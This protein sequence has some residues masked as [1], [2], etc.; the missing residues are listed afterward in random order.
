MNLTFVETP[1]FRATA[2]GVL[3][4]EDLRAVQA[5]LIQNPRVGPVERGTGGIRKVRVALAGRGKSGGA[6]VMYLYVER[7]ARVY[8]VLAYPKN[9]KG[10]LTDAEKQAVRTL[11]ARLEQEV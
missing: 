11:A 3:S 10:A 8:L 9:V 1:L 7:A 6:R 4:D 2:K 5:V